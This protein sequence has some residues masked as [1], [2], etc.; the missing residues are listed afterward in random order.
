MILEICADSV[1]SSVNAEAGG[2]GRLELCG[3]L[4]IGGI[5]PGPGTICSVL[6]NV[7][8]PVFVMIRPRGGDF[9]YSDYEFEVMRRDIDYAREAGAAGVVLGLLRRNGSIDTDRTAWLT[10][11]ASPLEVTFHRA[12]DLAADPF[13]A[14][15][16]VIAAGAS[17]ILTSGQQSSA[18]Q[19]A[20]LIAQLVERAGNRI[21]VMPGAGINQSNIR[22]LINLTGAKEYH[23]TGR[24][25]AESS[26]QFRRRGIPLG[27]PSLTNDEYLMRFAD[28]DTIAAIKSVMK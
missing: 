11:Y 9:L 6:A 26:M 10:E 8:I 17:R 5:T 7:S 13:V 25:V 27:H 22:Q 15:E 3:A 18:I 14:L 4:E 28:S 24:K 19:G 2:A 12:F 16:E 23:L 20:E 1:E 21:S